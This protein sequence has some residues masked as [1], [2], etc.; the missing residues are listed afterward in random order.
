MVR[1]IPLF[2]ILALLGCSPPRTE[3]EI[4]EE[5]ST[6]IKINGLYAEIEQSE[7]D[8]ARSNANWSLATALENISSDKRSRS[9]LHVE[10]V[11]DYW[12]AINPNEKFWRQSTNVPHEV[13]IYSPQ[14]FRSTAGTQ[15]VVIHFI[16]NPMLTNSLPT[17][18]PASLPRLQ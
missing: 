11:P 17:W 12:F 15:F 5:N 14:P 13:A 6:K 7:F 18:Q 4:I 1:F 2:S 3:K 9:L 8:A 10:A 16:G